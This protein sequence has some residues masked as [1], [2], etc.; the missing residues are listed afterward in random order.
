M[1][2]GKVGH[3]WGRIS[4]RP[5][6]AIAVVITNG[7]SYAVPLNA[8]SLKAWAVGN[9]NTQGGGGGTAYKTWAI[10][11]N[12]SSVSF[13]VGST[14]GASTSLTFQATTITGNG[15][16]GSTGGGHSGGDGGSN[17]G[18]GGYHAVSGV[19]L[20]QNGGAVGGN[21]VDPGNSTPS[22][23][24][25]STILRM[26]AADVS[27][28]LSAVALAG[29]KDVEDGGESPA[30]GSGCAD[31]WIDGDEANSKTMAA[32]IGGGGRVTS[33]GRGTIQ[34]GGGAVVLY[35]T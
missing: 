17:G 5:F 30:F 4:E 15:A 9:G 16:S 24:W 25:S 28:L 31:K 7:T 13:S 8:T 34:P 26:P 2:R 12:D 35:F 21:G 10:S 6:V 29:A 19:T 11:E 1:T 32:G 22:A 20:F 18:S 27:G 33:A 3:Y 14:N 23:A